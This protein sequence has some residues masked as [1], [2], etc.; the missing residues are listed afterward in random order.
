[1][2]EI[3]RSSKPLV[4]GVLTITVGVVALG[5]GIA[6]VLVGGGMSGLQAL[7]WLEFLAG[8]DIPDSLSGLTILSPLLL[9]SLGAILIPFGILSITG[10]IEAIRRRHWRLSLAG[11]LCASAV[12]PV[13]GIPSIVLVVISRREFEGPSNHETGHGNE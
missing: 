4:A 12:I 8:V 5:G 1:V 2:E 6:I 7:M 3:R 13:L 11:C 9:G 10:G